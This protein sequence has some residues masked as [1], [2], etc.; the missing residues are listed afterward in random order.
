[1][2]E[3][4]SR[5]AAVPVSYA[6][7]PPILGNDR[8]NRKGTGAKTVAAVSRPPDGSLEPGSVSGPRW[9][10]S[11]PIAPLD[12]PHLDSA[13]DNFHFWEDDESCT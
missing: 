6:L 9:P 5:H 8:E 12:G 3:K 11:V 1:M 2:T 13:L 4:S 7:H 10:S